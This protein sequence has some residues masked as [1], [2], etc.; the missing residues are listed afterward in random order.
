MKNAALILPENCYINLNRFNISKNLSHF[1]ISCILL[2]PL[3]SLAGKPANFSAPGSNATI[4]NAVTFHSGKSLAP[5]DTTESIRTNLYL[6]QTDNSLVLADGVYAEYNNL[7]HDSVTLEDAIK[8][9]NFLENIGLLRYGKTLSVERRPII[10][11]NDTLFFKLWNTTQRNYQIELVANLATN[12]G[13]QAYFVDSYLNTS[14]SLSLAATT[15]INFSVNADPGSAAIDRFKIIFKPAVSFSPLPV[16]FTD[17]KALRQ[18]EKV[19]VN[20]SVKNEINIIKYEIEKSLNGKYFSLVNTTLV[21]GKTSSTSNY[22]WLDASSDKGNI[23][24]RIKS[25]S[26]DSSVKY[27]DVVKVNM[28]Q[29]GASFTV[30]PNPVKGNN[31]N[32]QMQNQATGVYQVKMINIAGQVVYNGK[33]SVN[34]N[35]MSQTLNTGRNM[36]KGIYQLEFKSADKTSLIKTIVVQ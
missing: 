34:S 4:N 21:A 26:I 30:Y 14:T 28:L 20:W 23:F 2:I 7:Y 25:I 15:K 24:Y 9:T 33:V 36:P 11:A 22:L 17:V 18:G 1:F 6:L 12:I 27:T 16:T 35:S 32:L 13:L 10:K 3:F 5:V 8:F 29:N 19:A 31:I